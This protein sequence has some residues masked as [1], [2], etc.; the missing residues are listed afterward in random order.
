MSQESDYNLL[1]HLQDL[2]QKEVGQCR[3]HT[4][5]SDGS[6]VT[7]EDTLA[8]PAYL[9][10]AKTPHVESFSSD[11]KQ[12]GEH[13]K[14]M[15]GQINSSGFLWGKTETGG[16]VSVVTAEMEREKAAVASYLERLLVQE[17]SIVGRPHDWMLAYLPAGPYNELGLHVTLIANPRIFQES[18]RRIPIGF[19]ELDPVE[20]TE[21]LDTAEAIFQ[22]CRA[23]FPAETFAMNVN[24]GWPMWD[25]DTK[26]TTQ[27]VQ[28][29]HAQ[30]FALP[31]ER[32][33]FQDAYTLD[34]DTAMERS[35]NEKI[36]SLRLTRRVLAGHNILERYIRDKL[37]ELE[38]E[39]AGDMVLIKLEGTS[40][41]DA[42][43]CELIAKVTRWAEQVMWMER[44]TGSKSLGYSWSI[45]Q[46]NILK[47]GFSDNGNSTEIF[48]HTAII[49]GSQDSIIKQHVQDGQ[50]ALKATLPKMLSGLPT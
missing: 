29:I 18:D 23:S 26:A 24:R 35:L 13:L 28:S 31:Q 11:P 5:I 4:G 25:E 42:R 48:H 38:I 17:G 36:L 19:S 46:D 14:M 9:L 30:I 37:P 49:R 34:P 1:C 33:D 15:S 27:T 41:G 10:R 21:F 3:M 8:Y 32:V 7:P 45:E 6:T 22:W 44:V 2:E 47:L 40:W 50:N 43:N 12:F 16:L 39:N 20:Q